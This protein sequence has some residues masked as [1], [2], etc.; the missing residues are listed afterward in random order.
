MIISKSNPPLD[1]AKIV[2]K[3]IKNTEMISTDIKST[4]IGNMK[5]ENT[6]IKNSYKKIRNI[7]NMKV[8]RHRKHIRRIF[9]VLP[10]EW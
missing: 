3:K 9:T 10:P 6:I 4:K 1:E 7:C 2:P 8:G 5:M